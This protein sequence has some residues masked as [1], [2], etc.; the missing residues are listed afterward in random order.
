MR[1][2]LPDFTRH[3]LAESGGVV[4]P[5]P[6]GLEVL[7]PAEVAR[8][9]EIPEHANLSFS[10]NSGEG[11]SVSYNSEILKKMA[12]LIGD[13]GK[14]STVGFTPPLVRIEK[15]EEHLDKK[16]VFHNAVFRVERKEE[17]LLSYLLGYCKYLALSD[18]RQE[19]ILSC[20]INEL[21]LSVQKTTPDILDLVTRCFAEPP[22][23]A[24]RESDE[25]VLKT[26]WRAQ[27]EIVKEMLREFLQS[28]ERRM[29]RDIQRVHD[30]YQTLIH[31]HRQSLQ[32]KVSAAE[33]KEK[34][35]G[36]IEAIERELEGKIQD[37]I[38]KFSV[39]LRIEP[40][41]FIRVE[42]TSPVFWLL[43]RRRK[44]A[45]RFP[46]TYNPLLKSLDPL[47]CEACFYP[48]KGHYVCDDRLHILC[49]QCFGPCLGCGK[50]YCCAC[51]PKSCPRCG[52]LN[53]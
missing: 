40:I 27:T 1:S 9:L 25:R 13:R 17:K 36:R 51:H 21:N 24:E 18:D 38:G 37:L 30:Y 6:D 33:E 29:N 52:P 39:D 8:L 2:S 42:V 16:V 34:T 47:P 5:S 19:G 43:V 22:G 35:L 26:L 44:E 12:R 4:E 53:S 32:K 23:E 14:F 49:R 31:E 50:T 45:R 48:R 20:L 10:G 15:L 11:L 46:L 28:L 7:L 41:S 3:L